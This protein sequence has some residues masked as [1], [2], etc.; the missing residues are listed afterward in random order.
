M[1]ALS[2]FFGLPLAS[3]TV[4]FLLAI[5][6]GFVLGL[7]YDVFRILRL[8]VKSGFLVTLI[9]DVVYLIF[10]AVSSYS[11]ALIRSDGFLRAYI[12]IGEGLGAILY[13]FSLS[14]VIMGIS[15]L[16]I[17]MI[18]TVLGWIFTPVLRFLRF[19]GTLFEKI[20]KKVWIFVKKLL[21]RIMHLV[22]NNTKARQ[23]KKKENQKG[24]VFDDVQEERN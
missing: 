18:H 8:A 2:S 11:L 20:S 4:T 15:A 17:G 24:D 21:K 23:A 6:L 3:Q 12:L 9:E 19:L 5:L 1:T 16:V 22:Y 10:V 14:I 7:L 13:F